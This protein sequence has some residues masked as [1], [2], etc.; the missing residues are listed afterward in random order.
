MPAHARTEQ[1]TSRRGSPLRILLV[2]TRYQMRGGEDRVVDLDHALLRRRGHVVEAMIT[3]NRAIDPQSA[4]IA[5][6][7]QAIWSPAARRAIAAR[8]ESFHPDVVHVHN[9]F[10]LL[11]PAILGVAASFRVPVVQ[12]LHNYRVLCVNGL[13]MTD[14]MPCERCV[15][16]VVAW[17]GILRGCYRGSRAASAGVAAISAT[18]RLLGTWHD[19]VD[20][21]I[22]LSRFAQSRF[23]AGGLP[24]EKI[25]V[26]GNPVPDPGE[27]C[28][29]WDHPRSGALFVGRLSREKGIL[30]LLD[31]WKGI[32]GLL[33]VIGDG[34]LSEEVRRRSGPNVRILGSLPPEMVSSALREA[35]LVVIPSVCYENCPTVLLEAM[36]NGAAVVASDIGALA[37]MVVDGA[38]GILVPPNDISAL[39]RV[40][41]DL[42][43]AP[44]RLADLGAAGRR[45]F[46]SHH[47]PDDAMAA[48]ESI[49]CS[50]LAKTRDGR[51]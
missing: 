48:L 23:V 39:H 9:S 34:P 42:L 16:R 10:P 20:A 24:P 28:A 1:T 38:T 31:A 35:A 2:H 50:L 12:T 25:V 26:R 33:T 17:P 7:A 40:V 37:E 30:G 49:Y 5:T 15:G 51:C 45:H 43:A 32:D 21:F 11:S 4:G 13:L 46:M 18:H 41:E 47:A 22:A 29:S 27:H 36:A 44:G 6:V 8:I 3:D 19:K 14:D